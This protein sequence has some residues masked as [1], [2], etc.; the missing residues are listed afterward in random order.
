MFF[1]VTPRMLIVR[2]DSVMVMILNV[3]GR[4][5][6]PLLLVMVI[7]WH[8]CGGEC[9]LPLVSPSL[10]IVHVLLHLDRD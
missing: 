9:Y 2:G 6:D 8:L 5:L 4:W 7:D 10:D 3:K 1:Y